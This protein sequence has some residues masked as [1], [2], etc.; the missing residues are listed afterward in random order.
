MRKIVSATAAIAALVALSGCQK[1]DGGKG[2]AAAPAASSSSDEKHILNI[3]AWNEEFQQRFN[4]YFKDKLPKNVEVKWLITP[5][6][7]GAYQKKLDEFL[8]RQDSAAQNDKIDVFLVEA[9]YALKYT[10]SPYTLDVIKDVGL[11]QDDLKNQYKYTKDIMTDSNGSLK[12]TSWQACPGGFIY[13]RSIAKDV[14]GTDDPVAVGEALSDWNKFNAVA[15]QAKN[16]GYFMLS[17]YDDAFRVFSDNIKQPWVDKNKKIVVDP[18][19]NQW[20]EQTRMF[21]QL[22]YNQKASMWTSESMQGMS[23]SGKVF[24]YFGPAWFIDFVMA[25]ASLA[26]QNAEKKV[27]NGSYGDWAF[28]KGPMG[29]SWGGTWICAAKGSDDIPVIKDM[30]KTLTCDTA[31]MTRIAKEAGDFTNNEVAMDAIA[32]SDY[33]NPFLGGQNHTT[34]F[35]DSAKSIDKSCLS[36]YD[37]GMVEKLQIAMKDYFDGKITLDQAWDNFYT[38]VLE[39]Y[40]NL[41]R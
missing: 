37:Q 24:G 19:M 6:A 36:K 15:E 39:M 40:P 33:Q 16:K 30:M 8:L 35:L 13:R 26:D 32:K 10:D 25:P 31:T 2:G 22:G 5:N 14:L 27:G 12:G 9:D 34:F 20:I 29:F 3:C 1:Q 18:V 17:G 41:S 11:S 23:A 21:T 7:D 38:A 4:A 28:C